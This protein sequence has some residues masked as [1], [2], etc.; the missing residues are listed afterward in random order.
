MMKYLHTFVAVAKHASFAKAGDDIGLSHTGVSMHVRRLEED[1]GCKLFDRSGMRRV[2]LTQKGHELLPLAEQI[3]GKYLDLKMIAGA[4]RRG[5]RIRLGVISSVQNY[6]FPHAMRRFYDAFPAAEVISVPGASV[7]LLAKV[8]SGEIDMAIIDKPS[9]N[10]PKT[11]K[12]TPILREPYV[13][14]APLGS[15]EKTAREVLRNYG[16]IS[17]PSYSNSGKKVEEFLDKYSIYATRKMEQDDP[18]VILKL[19][20]QGVGAAITPLF[21]TYAV[22]DFSKKTQIYHLGKGM[23]YREVGILQ[24]KEAS[25][26]PLAVT[27]ADAFFKEAEDI[28]KTSSEKMN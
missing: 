11:L 8:D 24:R 15:R 22:A 13:V 28:V 19:V 17:Y 25:T 3:V 18:F 1:L 4:E 16:L 7:H 26:H 5:G 2:A 23:F 27:L 12:W 6:L 10:F 14:V 20:E 21:L 9:F